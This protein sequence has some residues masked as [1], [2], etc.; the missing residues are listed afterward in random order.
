MFDG[1]VT[2]ALGDSNRSAVATSGMSA[3]HP[4]VLTDLKVKCKPG[5]DFF[6]R[7]IALVSIPEHNVELFDLPKL[8]MAVEKSPAR[9]PEAQHCFSRKRQRPN[10]RIPATSKTSTQKMNGST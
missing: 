7:K 3:Y 8:R 2:T 9:P 5:H 1:F 10:Q 4:Q 6:R